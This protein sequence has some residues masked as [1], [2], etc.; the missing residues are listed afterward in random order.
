MEDACRGVRTFFVD[1][2]DGVVGV[3]VGRVAEGFAEACRC[4]ALLLSVRG[5]GWYSRRGREG[6]YSYLGSVLHGAATELPRKLEQKS[7]ERSVT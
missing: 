3:L 4:H 1:A 6:A 2:L 5:R 7:P